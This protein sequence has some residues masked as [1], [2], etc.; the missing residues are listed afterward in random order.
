MNLLREYIR[1]LLVE[2]AKSPEDLPKNVVVIIRKPA[3]A[4]G[5]TQIYYEVV[6]KGQPLWLPLGTITIVPTGRPD[7]G[8]CDGAMK[9]SSSDAERGWG[10]LLYDVAIEW[11]TLNANGLTSDRFGVSPD[12]R[13]VW[14]YYLNS[15]SDVTAHQLDDMKNALTPREEDNCDQRVAS[16]DSTALSKNADWVGSPLSKRYTKPPA[17]IEKLKSLGKL[18]VR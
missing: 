1:I 10:P 14:D 17:T 11:A 2:A 3:Q 7:T 18:V 15:R 4:S 12:A 16:W 8:P 9:V 5:M 13:R 6:G